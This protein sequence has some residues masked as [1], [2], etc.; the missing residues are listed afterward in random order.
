[1]KT[2][3]IIFDILF[4]CFYGF[5]VIGRIYNRNFDGHF[6]MSIIYIMLL[7]GNAKLL[8]SKDEELNMSS[9][10]KKKEA[11]KRSNKEMY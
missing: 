2:L 4:A 10:I 11:Q 1:M 3:V 9:R 8:S 7:L 5:S 6:F